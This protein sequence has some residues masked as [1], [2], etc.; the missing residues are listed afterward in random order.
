MSATGAARRCASTTS[1]A[2]CNAGSCHAKPDGQ[3][4]FRLTVFSYDPKSDYDEIVKHARGRRVFP[5]FPEE[6]LVLLKPTLAVP[7]EG[8]E[9]F[10]KDSD[11]FR[12]VARWIRTGMIFRAENE[13]ELQRLTVLPAERRYRKGATQ[14]LL[15]HA[16]YSDGS[17]RDVTAL[18]GFAANDKEIEI[19]RAHV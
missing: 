15:V 4:G 7:H 13:P 18:A 3:N 2:G 6:S 14:R 17:V 8:G 10:V 16:H 5:S 11:A 9:R 12:T 1:R 19:G